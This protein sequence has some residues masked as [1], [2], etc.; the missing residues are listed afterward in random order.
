MCDAPVCD[1]ANRFAM[2]VAFI[3]VGARIARHLLPFERLFPEPAK[4]TTNCYSAIAQLT[5]QLVDRRT[6]AGIVRK[7]CRPR[8]A[9]DSKCDN[10][11][12]HMKCPF[13]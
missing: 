7:K 9:D 1:T 6:G 3:E 8:M 2:F 13:F 11:V 4:L 12:F 10:K 5:L